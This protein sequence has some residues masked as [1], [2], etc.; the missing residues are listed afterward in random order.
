MRP[1]CKKSVY[2]GAVFCRVCAVARRNANTN[3]PTKTMTNIQNYHGETTTFEIGQ[4]VQ[5]VTDEGR[6]TTAT[7]IGISG[8]LLHLSFEDG[9][10]G[11][12]A[13][14]TCY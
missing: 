10:E 13:P 5:H 1:P 14:D 4:L 7:I 2:T 12:E 9:H 6:I 8:D 3:Q 11:S